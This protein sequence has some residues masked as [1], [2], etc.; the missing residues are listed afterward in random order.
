MGELNLHS[1]FIKP[2]ISMKKQPARDRLLEST[3]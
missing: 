2:I 1:K 3:G